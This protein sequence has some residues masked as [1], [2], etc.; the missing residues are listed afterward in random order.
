MDSEDIRAQLQKIV[1]SP[2]FASSE[3]LV[4]ILR[5][6]VIET[7]E[8]R[9]DQ[10]KEYVLGAGVLGKGPSF[11]PRVDPIVRMQVGRLR[12]KLDRYYQTD[13]RQDP[14]IIEIPK[15]RYVPVFHPRAAP[16]E[17][18]IDVRHNRR[19]M[20]AALLAVVL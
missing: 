9:G 6:I 19:M 14:I 5:T 10:L 15:G 12:S 18:R 13:G 2:V 20:L 11:D 3:S 7:I 1:L 4:R 16:A 8:G 17:L